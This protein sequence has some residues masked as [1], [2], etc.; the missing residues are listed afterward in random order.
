MAESR[1]P[2]ML[3]IASDQHCWYSLGVLDPEVK[4]PKPDR[5]AARGTLFQRA[6]CPNPGLH[7]SASLIMTGMP[8]SFAGA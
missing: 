6:C 2:T 1:G 7:A 5:L 4:T 8:K 3:L